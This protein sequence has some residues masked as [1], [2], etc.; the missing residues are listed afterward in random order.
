MALY[1]EHPE[2]VLYKLD[3]TWSEERG[4]LIDKYSAKV[5][6]TDTEWTDI[7][8]SKFYEIASSFLIEDDDRAAIRYAKK[9]EQFGDKLDLSIS[10]SE[11]YLR[12]G[13]DRKAKDALMNSLYFESDNAW[14]LKRKGDLLISFNE[15]DEAAE[16]F[17]RA[18][19]KD[20]SVVSNDSF[21]KIF[22]ESNAPDLARNYLVKDTIGEWDKVSSI[23][24]LLNHDIQY[25]NFDTAI[26]SYERMQELDYY[27]DFLG[28]KRI[29]LFLKSPFSGWTFNEFSH[30]F[31]LLV[32]LVILFL[33]PYLWVLPIYSAKKYFKI[34]VKKELFN[35]DW[36]LKHFWLI[37]FVF[38]FAQIMLVLVLYYQDYINFY[39]EVATDYSTE[40]IEET[41]AETAKANLFYFITLALLTVLFLNK[42][43]LKFIFNTT[44]SLGKII[45][46]SIG[47]VFV[48]L[49]V[50]K[51]ANALF[52][53][54]DIIAL[55]RSLNSREEIGAILQEY[56]FPFAVLIVAVIAPLYEEIIFRGIIL[57]SVEKHIGF[58]GANIIQ[59]TLFSLM[60]MNMQLFL[61]YFVFGLI[62]GYVAKQSRGLLA[63]FIFHFVNNFIVL[64]SIN[65]LTTFQV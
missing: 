18:K 28:I 26:Q 63:G 51:I 14:T 54:E 33:I 31:W 5:E 20:S 45:G 48:N 59:A 25:S 61:F 27:D 4:E 32:I 9:A 24:K 34:K 29:R 17:D 60:H 50:I 30:L 10:I 11:A 58:I 21:Y 37:S 62:T 42:K 41:A 46:M 65:V 43:R 56:G 23:Q 1:P 8:R 49:I 64:V 38:L 19:V 53:P 12:L 13:E 40:I 39:F 22:S 55:I 2:V 36:N 3:Y 44:F 7:Q 47:F 35:V 52:P 6:S 15:I 16:M 57:T